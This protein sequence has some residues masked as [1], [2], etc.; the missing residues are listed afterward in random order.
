MGDWNRL[1]FQ[2]NFDRITFTSCWFQSCFPQHTAL[3]YFSLASRLTCFPPSATTAKMKALTPSVTQDSQ[4]MRPIMFC[5]L[6]FRRRWGLPEARKARRHS[7]M[8]RSGDVAISWLNRNTGCYHA[9]NNSLLCGHSI[10]LN[11]VVKVSYSIPGRCSRLSK[12][13]MSAQSARI[14]RWCLSTERTVGRGGAQE[15][16]RSGFG[17]FASTLN[18]SGI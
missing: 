13:R 1:Q 8:L 12:R 9:A 17:E 7:C 5:F 2:V 15:F 6:M 3:F 14:L 10:K 4:Q 16:L 11:M 18:T